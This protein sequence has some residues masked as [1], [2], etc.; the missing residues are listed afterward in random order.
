MKVFLGVILFV[1]Q[2]AVAQ[3]DPRPS[4]S[5]SCT[6]IYEISKGSILGGGAVSAKGS[7]TFPL[8]YPSPQSYS[9]TESQ[10]SMYSGIYYYDNKVSLEIKIF[11]EGQSGWQGL[12]SVVSSSYDTF[13]N[14]LQISSF[15]NVKE[16]IEWYRLNCIKQ[17]TP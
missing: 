16:K 12:L 7:Q 11:R 17:P 14:V 8:T 15:I 5:Y 1:S 6:F 10:R 13:Q 2:V 4:A 3:Q 9:F